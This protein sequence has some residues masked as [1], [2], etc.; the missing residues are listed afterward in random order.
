MKKLA[1]IWLTLLA[2]NAQSESALDL[3]ELKRLSLLFPGYARQYSPS[4][5]RIPPELVRQVDLRFGP[6]TERE[7]GSCRKGGSGNP[8]IVINYATWTKYDHWQRQEVVFHEYGHCILNR[9][10]DERQILIMGE[11]MHRSLMHPEMMPK[12]QY[13]LHREYYLR[14]L[15]SQVREIPRLDIKPPIYYFID[16]DDEYTP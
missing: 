14:E 4:K 6:T 7:A 5:I 13:L 15:F 11:Q 10:H 8:S 9:E 3:A 1:I 12:D 16:E 2:A